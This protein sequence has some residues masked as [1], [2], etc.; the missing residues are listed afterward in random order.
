MYNNPNLGLLKESGMW[1]WVDIWN[2]ALMSAW[3]FLYPQ[4]GHFPLAASS[5]AAVGVQPPSCSCAG[6]SA[7]GASPHSV[8][9]SLLSG[10]CNHG[11]LMLLK[12]PGSSSPS[13]DQILLC[14]AVQREE[15]HRARCLQVL[16]SSATKE[17]QE[18]ISNSTPSL[19]HELL[20]GVIRA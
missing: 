14:H 16:G 15:L 7:A 12:P 10:G 1:D 19:G 3:Q 8:Q 5:D 20:G 6:G 18:I 11:S 13:F 4:A 9:G 17:E 2:L